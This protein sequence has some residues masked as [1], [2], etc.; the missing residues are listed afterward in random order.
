MQ[1]QWRKWIGEREA[2]VLEYECISTGFGSRP[3]AIR[4]SPGDSDKI[5]NC[6]LY[7]SWFCSG[8]RND[9]IVVGRRGWKQKV[10][11][12]MLV[13]HR[14]VDVKWARLR[15][16]ENSYVVFAEWE[17]IAIVSSVWNVMVQFIKDVVE[18]Q[19]S[20]QFLII[21]MLKYSTG[22]V[23][24][25]NRECFGNEEMLCYSTGYVNSTGNVMLFNRRMLCYSTVLCYS[26]GNVMLFNRKCYVIQQGMLCY[27]TGNVMGMYVIQQGECYVIQQEMLFKRECYST[28]NVMLFNRKCY[29]IQQ[30]M[31]CYSTGNVML[32]NRK[33]LFN[34]CYVIQQEMLWYSMD[35]HR[36]T[37]QAFFYHRQ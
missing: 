32:F 25:L 27:S 26:T 34:R 33:C 5:W 35:L 15:I 3:V 23:E 28:G 13:R 8:S 30:G 2:Q 12:W 10:Q 11:E 18:F 14:S 20:F 29:V 22:N 9:G 31:L 4:F 21:I 24:V 17:L 36:T 19:E 37:W 1:W 6:S 16:T 7:N